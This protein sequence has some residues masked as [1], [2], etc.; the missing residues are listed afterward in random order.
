[1]ISAYKAGDLLIEQPWPA[2]YRRYGYV[3]SETYEPLLIISKH[4]HGHSGKI[5]YK[6]WSIC[7]SESFE[8]FE[9]ILVRFYKKAGD[10]I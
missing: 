3:L 7:K 1:M 8:F 9:D 4:S 2:L 5:Y 6:T 10:D